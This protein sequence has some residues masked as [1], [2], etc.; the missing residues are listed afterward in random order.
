LSRH[1]GSLQA[2]LQAVGSMTGV[3]QC[4]R[5]QELAVRW[6]VCEVNSQEAYATQSRNRDNTASAQIRQLDLPSV[7]TTRCN[8]ELLRAITRLSCSSQSRSLESHAALLGAS[9]CAATMRNGCQ[10]SMCN[11]KPGNCRT[12]T[13]VLCCE[14]CQ[15]LNR[16]N[17]AIVHIR[18]FDISTVSRTCCALGLLGAAS[19]WS[20]GWQGES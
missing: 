1:G 5:Y 17:T 14:E 9:I 8:R 19:G 12:L 7:P 10:R 13:L 6:P 18:Q 4:L 16:D 3:C 11:I 2:K 20:C 15:S